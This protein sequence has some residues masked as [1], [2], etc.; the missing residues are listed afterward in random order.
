LDADFR[1]LSI[2]TL[3]AVAQAMI[4]LTAK[5][6]LG[7]RWSQ[8]QVDEDSQSMLGLRGYDWPYLGSVLYKSQRRLS[9]SK[10]SP[11]RAAADSSD[12]SGLR[13]VS[14][15]HQRLGPWVLINER[16]YKIGADLF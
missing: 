8:E 3:R 11:R 2:A 9:R 16:W 4:R 1:N 10:H 13:A 14:V 12:S 5:I 7:Q 6:T 15:R